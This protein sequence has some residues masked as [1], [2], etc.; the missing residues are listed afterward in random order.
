MSDEQ[1]VRAFD[2]G[3][4]LDEIQNIINLLESL[5]A[6]SLSSVPSTI[7]TTTD[8]EQTYYTTTHLSFAQMIVNQVISSKIQSSSKFVRKFC[9]INK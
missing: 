1:N 6:D 5:D 7:S 4:D 9:T 3:I 2:C 8:E